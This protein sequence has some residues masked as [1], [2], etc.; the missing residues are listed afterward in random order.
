MNPHLNYG[1]YIPG[2]NQ[3]RG[4]GIIE[5][6]SPDHHVPREHD[7]PDPAP[8]RGGMEGTGIQGAGGEDRR[9][10]PEAD[11]DDA[12]SLTRLRAREVLITPLRRQ[13]VDLHPAQCA[14][15]ATKHLPVLHH[16][17]TQESRCAAGPEGRD[18]RRGRTLAQEDLRR[19]H[20][21]DSPDHDL[22]HRGDSPR[23]GRVLWRARH[24]S[25]YP[26]SPRRRGCLQERARQQQIIRTCGVVRR[27]APVTGEHVRG[28]IRR[29]PA[30]AAPSRPDIVVVQTVEEGFAVQGTINSFVSVYSLRNATIGSTRVARRA[31]TYDAIAATA[32]KVTATITNVVPSSGVTPKR[33]ACR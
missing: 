11:P 24:L 12:L 30:L 19:R 1:Q 33:I 13:R 4:I 23:P 31:G 21:K 14:P 15:L 7:S 16:P 3:G 27:P 8:R 6:R 10:Q 18:V 2:I 5:T 22:V 26:G 17:R 20:R 25:Q 9:R 32:A 29:Y 28:H